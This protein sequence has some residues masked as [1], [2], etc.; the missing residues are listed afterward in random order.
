MTTGPSNL[1]LSGPHG[2]IGPAAVSAAGPVLPTPDTDRLMPLFR[3]APRPPFLGIAAAL[4]ALVLA[5]TV[6]RA[7]PEGADQ[8]AASAATQPAAPAA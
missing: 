4:L 3:R 1:T 5:A 7:T 6:T 2:T 8:P